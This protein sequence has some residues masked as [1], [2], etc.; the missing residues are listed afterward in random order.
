[1]RQQKEMHSDMRDT[2]NDSETEIS[3]GQP[4]IKGRLTKI[5]KTLCKLVIT[6][7]IYPLSILSWISVCKCR[8]YSGLKI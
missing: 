3:P 4:L 8:D 6:V 1:M 7:P 2:K 5:L